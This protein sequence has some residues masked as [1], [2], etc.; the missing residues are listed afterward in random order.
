MIPRLKPNLGVKELIS[1]IQF[2]KKNSINKFEEKFSELSKQKHSVTFSHGRT[3]L[4][5]LLQALALK[6]KE[7]ICPAYTCVVV[8]HAITYS[9]N[10]PVFLDSSSDGFNMDLDKIESLINQKTGAIIATSI[11]GYPINLEKIRSLKNKYP[12]IKIIQDCAHSYFAEWNKTPVQTVGDAAFYGMNISK[13]ITSIFG[14]MVTTDDPGL[15]NKIIKLKQDSL[16]ENK[17]KIIKRLLYLIAMYPVF[18]PP[19]YSL[20]NYLERKKLLDKFVKYYDESSINMPSDY[21]EAFSELEARVG[22]VNLDR[23]KEQIKLRREAAEYYFSHLSGFED[24]ILP[25]KVEGATYSHYVV[26]VKNRQK[27]LNLALNKGIQ[28]GELIEYNI[29]EMKSYGSH[30]SNQFPNSAHYSRHCINLP[31]WGGERIA[32]KVVKNLRENFQS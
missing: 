13:I 7:V 17:F 32:E 5:Y 14:G 30:S 10:K 12:N 15:Y 1:A 11:F 21:L 9:G 2:Y 8:P 3:G 27:W 20:I 23:Y 18:N 31:V 6:D 26:L 4:I 19:I 29:P 28:L 22:I 24:F 25:P 16:V